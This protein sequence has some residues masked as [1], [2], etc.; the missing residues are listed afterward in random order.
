MIY[1]PR[2]SDSGRGEYLGSTLI[3]QLILSA[4]TAGVL[5]IAAL[6]ISVSPRSRSLSPVIFVLA[7]GSP[8][9]LFKEYVRGVC[10]AGLKLKTVLAVDACT[11]F[12]QIGGML[13][14]VSVGALGANRAYIVMSCSCGITGVGWFLATRSKLNMNLATAIRH[15]KRSWSFGKWVLADY[16]T[17]ILNSQIYPWF[18]AASH[19]PA[20][21]GA[22]AAC[23][24]VVSL[25]NP[26][27]LSINNYL[28]PKTS[29]AYASGGQTRV[30]RI[31]VVANV[32]L[33]VT[34]GAFCLMFLVWGGQIVTYVY[35]GNYANYGLIAFVLATAAFVG[36]FGIPIGF[37]FLAVGRP[38]LNFKSHLIGLTLTLTIG[39]WLVIL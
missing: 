17:F 10:F 2:E 28:G 15:F 33:T 12:F 31:L 19:G 14:L 38:D 16:G 3:H 25:S 36:T 22:L 1:S 18:V 7:I 23:S 6:A 9:I 8:L 11:A 29:Q 24:G 21:A 35:G 20:A 30:H 13:L 4:S 34:M 5:S 32:L 26:L 39:L 27:I 37:V